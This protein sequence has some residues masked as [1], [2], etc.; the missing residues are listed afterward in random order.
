MSINY[1]LKG[2]LGY[3]RM[4]ELYTLQK[5]KNNWYTFNDVLGI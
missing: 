3:D 1:K 2:L 4:Y 5:V